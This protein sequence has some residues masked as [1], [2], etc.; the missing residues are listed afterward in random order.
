MN[1]TIKFEPPDTSNTRSPQEAVD[2]LQAWARAV[3][4]KLNMLVQE[5]SRKVPT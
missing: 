4:D 1:L 5:I 2:L 3:T